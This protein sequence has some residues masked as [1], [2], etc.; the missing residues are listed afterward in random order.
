MSSV[1][2][3][4]RFSVP[5]KLTICVTSRCNLACRHCYTD[6]GTHAEPE[7]TSVEWIRFLDELIADGFIS[8]FFE[9][10][11]PFI[12]DD[13]ELI[14]AHA[15]AKMFVAI[16]T[17]ATLIDAPRAARLAALHVGRVYVDLLGACAST[18]D[19]MTGVA[20]TFA[21]A[22]DGIRNLRSH[23]IRTTVLIILTRENVGELQA[24]LE[25]AHSLGCDEVGVLRLYPLGRAKRNWTALSLSV[26]EMQAAID[27]LRAPSG[28]VLMQSWHPNDGNCCW[29]NAAV[30]PFG[31]SIGCPY[32]REYVD[33]GNV[34]RD[35]FRETWN[36]P[37]YRTL[38][39]GQVADTCPDCSGTQLTRGG[40]RSTAYAFH[41][42]WDA[43]D[44]FCTHLNRG[45]DLRV[46][47][48]RLFHQES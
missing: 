47:P 10:G 14:V 46:L 8:I 17:N 39:S 12:R 43:P 16:R 29:Q 11:E 28:I 35:S 38:R 24:T 26:D 3:E 4:S 7:L 40:C 5:F 42:R 22:I 41:G 37:L 30:D 13:F 48:E 15:T 45:V 25:L 2:A 27:G 32:L 33:Y 44:P 6:C 18:H 9:G 36:H 20:G 19:R 23:G 31:R 1:D 34:R 21:T